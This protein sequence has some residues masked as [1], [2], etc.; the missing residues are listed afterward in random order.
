MHQSFSV[1]WYILLIRKSQYIFAKKG[2]TK[3]HVS[4]YVYKYIWDLEIRQREIMKRYNIHIQHFLATITFLNRAVDCLTAY[5]M[6]QEILWYRVPNSKVYGTKMG[7]IWG[8]QD[9]GRPHVGPMDL[10]IWGG[11]LGVQ[12]G[13]L[14]GVYLIGHPSVCVFRLLGFGK[15]MCLVS[16]CGRVYRSNII[17]YGYA[18]IAVILCVS[19][20]QTVYVIYSL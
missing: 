14:R 16:D 4:I 5:H 9:P 11:M 3:V 2:N 13:I 15:W 7:P 8:R 19:V 6:A 20:Y 10:A 18:L 12:L 1:L 17:D